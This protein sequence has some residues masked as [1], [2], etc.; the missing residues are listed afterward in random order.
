MVASRAMPSSTSTRRAPQPSFCPLDRPVSSAA[1]ARI[2]RP[3]PSVSKGRRGPSPARS[4]M[5]YRPMARPMIEKGTARKK[6]LRQP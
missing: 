3:K 4:G 1:S 2:S 5:V 6:T